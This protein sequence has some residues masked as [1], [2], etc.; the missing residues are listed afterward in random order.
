MHRRALEISG[1]FAAETI[2]GAGS[3]KSYLVQQLH[4]S[5]A[6]WSFQ[7]LSFEFANVAGPVCGAGVGAQAFSPFW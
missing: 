5:Q 6:R 4:F 7:Q 3:W 2:Q 1:T